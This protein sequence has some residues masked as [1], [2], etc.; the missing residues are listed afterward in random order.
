[1]QKKIGEAL[2]GEKALAGELFDGLI[3]LFFLTSFV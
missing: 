1:M 2:D 3:V